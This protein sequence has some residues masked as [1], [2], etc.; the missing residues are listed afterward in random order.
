MEGL[1]RLHFF[2]GQ[3]LIA[4]DLE[5]EQ[6][7][8]IRVRRLLNRG[9]YSAGVVSGLEVTKVDGRH[10]RVARGIALDPRGREVV[11]LADTTLAVPNRLPVS[12]LPGYFLVIQ[13]G[14]EAEP[15]VMADCKESS[16]TTPPSRIRE[17]PVLSFTETWPNQKDCG[18]PG[19]ASDCAVVLALVVLD[20]SCHVVNIDSGV[21]QYAHSQLPRNVHPVAFEGEKDIDSS[22]PKKLHFQVRGGIP[23]AVLLSLWVDAISSLFYTELGSHTHTLTK[24]GANDVPMPNHRHGVGAVTTDH[25]DPETHHHLVSVLF[26]QLDDTNQPDQIVNSPLTA[27]SN[28]TYRNGTPP[29]LANDGAHTHHVTIPDT[30]LPTGN[31]PGHH[32]HSL[33]GS[34]DLAGNSAPAT[35][36]TPYQARGG[37]AYSYPD[38]LRV[39]LD[40]TDITG[41]I[42]GKLGWGKLGD[43][44]AAHPLATNGTGAVDLLQLGLSL[45][46]GPHLIE[47]RVPSGGGK[48]LYNLYV[49]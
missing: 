35:G 1:E 7:Y 30:G 46:V 42:T 40:G 25:A 19:H 9:L 22:N 18:S 17:A 12:S 20:A 36:A 48:V 47:L 16:G 39:K 13:Y 37:P 31:P 23:Q 26:N 38:N 11:L 21:R 27:V 32:S 24:A 43:G 8:H 2:N 10:V 14:E 44:T 6:R 49:E 3:R 29:Y 28:A 45:S 33:T 34:A 15:G 41:L 5:L 4:K